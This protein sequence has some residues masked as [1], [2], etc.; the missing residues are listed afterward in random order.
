[1][2][3]H[4]LPCNRAKDLRGHQLIPR[5]LKLYRTYKELRL[6]T[7]N[8][9]APYFVD[10]PLSVSVSHSAKIGVVTFST[11]V[12]L[13]C[14]FER[15]Q[16]RRFIEISRAYFHPTESAHIA[17]EQNPEQLFYKLW[18]LKEAYGKA[19]KIG[20]T[21]GLFED[22]STIKNTPM[23]LNHRRS[24]SR[25]EFSR[26]AALPSDRFFSCSLLPDSSFALALKT[27]RSHWA[28]TSIFHDR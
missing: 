11:G 1:M 8:R 14:D 27:R 3:C 7:S 2:H 15:H 28:L 25:A 24:T 22:F 17:R 19:H 4:V 23:E 6:S 26:L 13:G 20:L 16:N 18:T 5:A 9:G 10:D 21:K 12:Q